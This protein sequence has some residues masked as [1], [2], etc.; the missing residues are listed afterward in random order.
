MRMKQETTRQY[1][2]GASEKGTKSYPSALCNSDLCQVIDLP[3]V[4]ELVNS[5]GSK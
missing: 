3:K 5:E 2:T 1:R 4:D